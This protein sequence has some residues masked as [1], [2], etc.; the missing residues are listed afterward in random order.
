V[1]ETQFLAQRL[2]AQTHAVQ[3]L[4][5]ALL[6]V[7]GLRLERG[8]GIVQEY[9]TTRMSLEAVRQTQNMNMVVS[10]IV[11]FGEMLLDVWEPIK[12]KERNA[13]QQIAAT[14]MKLGR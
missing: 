14:I 4:E 13:R 11:I 5:H 1:L 7:H 2:L 10:H 3:L 8:Q 9:A 6:G 12:F